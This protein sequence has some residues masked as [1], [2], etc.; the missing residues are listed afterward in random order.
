MISV[1]CMELDIDHSFRLAEISLSITALKRRILYSFI[2][3]SDEDMQHFYHNY[4][5]S[6]PEIPMFDFDSRMGQ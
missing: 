4:T 6:Q 5:F 3:V 2:C 1:N